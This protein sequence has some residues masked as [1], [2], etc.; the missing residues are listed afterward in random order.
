MKL[1]IA[2]SMYTEIPN[3]VSSQY[4]RIFRSVLIL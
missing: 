2:I 1:K 4:K 3:T